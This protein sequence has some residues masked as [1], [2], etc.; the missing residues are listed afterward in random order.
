MMAWITAPT[1]MARI[2]QHELTAAL[3]ISD[4]CA[5]GIANGAGTEPR[6]KFGPNAG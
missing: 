2:Y 6:I 1:T 4:G 5:P 3:E